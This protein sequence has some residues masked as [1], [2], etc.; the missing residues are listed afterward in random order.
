MQDRAREFWALVDELA[1]D[2]DRIVE[3]TIMGSRCVRVDEEFLALHNTTK[4][5]GLVVKLPRDR[6]DELVADGTGRSFAPA[7]RVFGEWVSIPTWDETR[8]RDLLQEGIAFVGGADNDPEH[9]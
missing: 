2:D 6:V 5:W 3:G 7:G 4:D 8:W 9:A 1:D